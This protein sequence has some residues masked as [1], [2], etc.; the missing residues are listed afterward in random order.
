MPRPST[1][2]CRTSELWEPSVGLSYCDSFLARRKIASVSKRTRKRN[3]LPFFLNCQSSPV[4]PLPPFFL[5]DWY[6]RNR[7]QMSTVAL[8]G[9]VGLVFLS[10]RAPSRTRQA[11]SNSTIIWKGPMSEPLSD[12]AYSCYLQDGW[13][14]TLDVDLLRDVSSD[15][16][17]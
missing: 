3:A 5:L 12:V 4:R 13:Y 7:Y 2:R 11:W 8:L 1:T 17:Y 6:G 15:D 9:T 16:S 14:C 10:S